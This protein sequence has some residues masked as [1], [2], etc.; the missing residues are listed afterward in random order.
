MTRVDTVS[1]EIIASLARSRRAISA[2]SP[3]R[4]AGVYL[5][6][7]F[8]LH[9]SPMHKEVFGVLQRAAHQRGVRV[10]LAAPR[11]HAK[12]TVVT[13]AMVLWCVLYGYDPFVWIVSATKEQAH[14]LLKNIKDELETNPRLRRDF[15]R[16]CPPAG[17]ARAAPWRGSLIRLP[18]GAEIRAVSFDQQIRGIRSRQYRPSLIVVDDGESQ[19]AVRS[20]EQREVLRSVFEKTLLKAGDQRTNVVVVGTVLHH[21]SLL[22]R[23]LDPDQSPGWIGLRYRAL[24]SQPT[25]MHLW[26][27]WKE[28]Y[29]GRTAWNGQKHDDPSSPCTGT[30]AGAPSLVP[31][32]PGRTKHRPSTA[33]ENSQA[34]RSGAT[35][36]ERA[37]TPIAGDEP[38][39]LPLGGSANDSGFATDAA[40]SFYERHRSEMDEGARVL[41][42]EKDSLYALMEMRVR[43]GESSFSSEKQNEPLDPEQCIFQ[44][45]GHIYWDDEFESEQALMHHIGTGVEL[46]GA[47]DPSMGRNPRKGD[48]SAVIFIVWDPRLKTAYV[49]AA[50]I[51]RRT[52]AEAI[53]R[54]VELGRLY[55]PRYFAVE[56]NGFQELVGRDLREA[57]SRAGI[58]LPIRAVKHPTDKV[59]RI[60]TMQPSFAQG[61][62][63]LRRSHFVLNDQLRQ[64][65]LAKHDDGPDALQ[66]A[67][68]VARI[69]KP[70]M[71]V[72]GNGH[73]PCW[74]AVGWVPF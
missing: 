48:H 35:P 57:V 27:R 51:A 42:A 37:A 26:A 31:S 68:E 8:A 14:Q 39:P 6:E 62:L 66:M 53:A 44:M 23:L 36:G 72:S 64:F 47:W 28:I 13:L 60:S 5:P 70:G 32:S 15:P 24:I 3:E 56:E 1:P 74:Q 33:R 10:A 52:P 22:A 50:D 7:H 63:R 29:C 19:E 21:E 25:R 59:A 30:G 65:P 18:S 2:A 17:R 43:E 54:I 45:E 49:L 9:A 71:R 11:G 41:W 61:K 73:M 4:F 67:L 16:A 69:P 38:A 34:A 20:P 58:E 55:K 46:Y 12:S 40:R